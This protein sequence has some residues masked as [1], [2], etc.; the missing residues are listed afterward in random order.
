MLLNNLNSFLD[1]RVSQLLAGD[2]PEPII[3]HPD[4]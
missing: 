2:Q 3:Y 4:S 1:Q